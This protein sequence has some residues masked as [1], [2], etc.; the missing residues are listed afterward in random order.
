MA[1]SSPFELWRTGLDLWWLGVET[2][3]VMTMRLMGMAGIWSIDNREN[4]R[5]F[6][7]KPE[8]FGRALMRGTIAAAT[9]QKPHQIVT[10]ATRPIRK[11]TKSNA[12]RLA[13]RGPKVKL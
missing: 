12:R 2:Q 3:A 10:A 11:K 4:S 1:R 9:G 5:M 13:R 7:E 8:A 6:F